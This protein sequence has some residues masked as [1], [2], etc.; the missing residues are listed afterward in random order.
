[1]VIN[2]V[3]GKPRPLAER[4]R[5]WVVVVIIVSFSAAALAG[6]TVLF[7]DV[8]TGPVFEVLLSTALI[9]TF[10]V[11]VLCGATLLA[12]AWQAFG[13]VTIV[14][15]VASLGWCLMLV[16]GRSDWGDLTWRLTATA[17]MVTAALAIAS[18]LLLLAGHRA[19]IVRVAL[20]ATLGLIAVGVVL[21]LL[22]V[23]DVEFANFDT[24][25]R[26]LGVVWILAALGTVVLPTVSLILRRAQ[27]A[28]PAR[29]AVGG[30]SLSITS[31]ERINAAAAAAGM[32]P[33]EFLDSILPTPTAPS[34]AVVAEPLG[35][36]LDGSS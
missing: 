7:G 32:S 21:T 35:E 16:W 24:Y 12:R 25:L 1:M 36:H 29:P 14:V 11:A 26:A 2:A 18:L 4:I 22:P 30:L 27:P 33:D 5:R 17:S 34:S 28:P 8:D 19:A 3:S 10:G 20:F 31:V 6:I 13:W 15:A 9:G 23:W